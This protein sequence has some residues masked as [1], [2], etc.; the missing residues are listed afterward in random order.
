MKISMEE[1][2]NWGLYQLLN[3]KMQQ[4]YSTIVAVERER[5]FNR[6]NIRRR[7]GQ[8]QNQIGISKLICIHPF[9][10]GRAHK[11][12]HLTRLLYKPT[13]ISNIPLCSQNK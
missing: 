3:Q 9:I 11:N 5:E 13:F 1:E 2:E 4:L 6:K 7:M 8:F 10:F 12:I